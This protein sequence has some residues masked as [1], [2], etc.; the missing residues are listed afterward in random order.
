MTQQSVTQAFSGKR[1]EHIWQILLSLIPATALLVI[2]AYSSQMVPAQNELLYCIVFLLG[3]LLTFLGE[4]KIL[5]LMQQARSMRYVELTGAC[6]AFLAGN[7]GI[8][9]AVYGHDELTTLATTIN[10]LLDRQRQLLQQK[11]SPPPQATPS[12]AASPSKPAPLAPSA[13]QNEEVELLKG[14]LMQI[15][16][17]LSPVTKGDLRVHMSIPG[18]LVGIVAD[19]CNSFIEELTQ[20]VKWTRYAAQAVA[21]ASRSTLDRSIEMAKNTEHQMRRLSTTTNHIEEIA[22]FMQQLNNKLYLN[23]DITKEVQK[24]IRAKM[25]PDERASTT[26][27]GQLLNELQ[28]QTEFLEGIL[29]SAEA[30]SAVTEPLISDLYAVSQQ[31]YQSS[32]STLNTV[33]RLSELE[34]LAERWYKAAAAFTVFEGDEAEA[35]SEPWLL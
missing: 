13:P 35:A 33:K 30:S 18:N 9:V 26:C 5:S 10:L 17:E 34:A 8:K 21:T 20:F 3:A 27:A 2:G 12:V 19:A 4:K 31:I 16:N 1:T 28:R 11:P 29:H 32:I 25:L 14:Q 23:L 6:N 15:I 7:L 24:T 22:L